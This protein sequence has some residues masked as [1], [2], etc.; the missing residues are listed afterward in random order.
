MFILAVFASSLYLAHPESCGSK[1]INSFV[2]MNLQFGENR[3]GIKALLRPIFMDDSL[4]E[5]H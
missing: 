4:L 5:F 3:R 1:H 2:E